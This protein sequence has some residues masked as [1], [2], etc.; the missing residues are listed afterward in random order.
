MMIVQ[1][2]PKISISTTLALL[3]TCST[4]MIEPQKKKM[5]GYSQVVFARIWLL[6]APFVCVTNR[7][8]PYTAQMSFAALSIIGG[9]ITTL[10][11]PSPETIKQ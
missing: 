2:T 6:T 11:T 5:T 3:A 9:F 1:W 10:I 4:E 8:A 7:F